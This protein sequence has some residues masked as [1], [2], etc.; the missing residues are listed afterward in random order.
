MVSLSYTT[1]PTFRVTARQPLFDVT[2]YVIGSITESHH[3][4]VTPDGQSFAIVRRVQQPGAA[5]R[6]MV[7]V[8]DFLS[9]LKAHSASN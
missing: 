6:Q 5:P 9:E 7:V 1:E 2:R 3:Y 4:D 8:F